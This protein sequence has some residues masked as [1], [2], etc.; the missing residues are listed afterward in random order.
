MTKKYAFEFPDVPAESEYL[1]VRYSANAPA[2]SQN[3]S[4]RSFSHVFGTNTSR[5]DHGTILHCTCI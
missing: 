1:E 5:Y 3:A 2:P 4:G